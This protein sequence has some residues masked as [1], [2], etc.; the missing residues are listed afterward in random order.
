M[1][2]VSPKTGY[3]NS[4]RKLTPKRKDR[5][6]GENETSLVRLDA[7][8]QALA[9]AKTIPE[10]KQL[11]D[12]ASAFRE[13]LKRQKSSRQDK[14]KIAEYQLRCERKLGDFLLELPKERGARPADMGFDNLTPS[15]SDYGISKF[16]SHW[17][18]Q[19]AGIPEDE[20][21][22]YVQEINDDEAD[23]LP[24]STLGF[25][26]WHLRK[27]KPVPSGDWLPCPKVNTEH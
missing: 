19:V 23:K 1:L 21:A 9:E 11:H 12:Q 20:L 26:R 15:Y 16:Q 10:V 7:F 13:W 2:G 17:W 4:S 27:H 25:I 22:E 3:G 6:M 24:L 14:N 18:Q 5:R 8:T